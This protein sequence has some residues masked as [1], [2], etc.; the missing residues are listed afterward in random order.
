MSS[1]PFRIGYIDYKIENFHANVYLK[2][3]RETL[4]DRNAVIAGCWAL[5][6]EMGQQWAS[7]NAVTWYKSPKAMNAH[8]DAFMVLAPANPELHLQLVKTVA[9]FGKPIYL[10]KPSAPDTKTLHRIFALCDQYNAPLQTTSALRYTAIQEKV[11]SMPAGDLQHIV[12]WAGGRSFEEYGIH[13]VELAVSCM[14][15][16][17]EGLMRRTNGQFWQLLVNFSGGRTATIHSNIGAATPFSGTLITAKET[18]HMAPDTSKLFIDTAAAVL[19]FLKSG[20]PNIPREESLAVRRILDAAAKPAS[21]KK[22][23]KV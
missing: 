11:R 16:E 12:T 8:V 1:Q 14:G 10:D 2:A 13:P 21:L 7:K 23:I 22:F 3:Y 15:G 18:I 9:R 5:D 6:E 19:D 20:K 4:A 17:V